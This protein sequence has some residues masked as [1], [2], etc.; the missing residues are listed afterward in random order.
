MC[1]GDGGGRDSPASLA[2]ALARRR[3]HL[4]AFGDH[5]RWLTRVASTND[6]AARWAQAG[7]PEGAWVVADE[8]TAGRGRR[9][10]AWQSPAGAG[11]YLSLVFRPAAASAAVSNHP[12]TSLLT[13]MTGV[14][15][16]EGIRRATGVAV[17]LK[18]PNDV[19]VDASWRKL[20]GILAEATANGGLVQ[21][22]IV[23]V[24][25]NLAP[26]SY[27][28]DVAE[29]AVALAELSPQPI[30]R[31]VVL[32]EILAAVAQR[33]ARLL[34]GG[35]E[36]LLDAWRALAPS[37][38]GHRVQWTAP[39]GARSGTTAGI[40]ADGAL[41]VATANGLERIIAGEV[42]W[43]ALDDVRRR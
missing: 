11:L 40:D 25:V 19:I 4:G 35:S 10:R 26:A 34:G 12:A 39:D 3:S 29:R 28:S 21:S 42:I 8:Q 38:R 20:A 37:S 16:A 15:V 36:E 7:A 5:G 9:G 33:R 30:D 27:P 32:V 2:R 23:G 17:T 13:L 18:W 22:V 1:D 24:G 43:D 41:L 31:D 14:A 6:E